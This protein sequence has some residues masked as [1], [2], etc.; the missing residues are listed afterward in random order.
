MIEARRPALL[1]VLGEL[2]NRTSY[3]HLIFLTGWRVQIFIRSIF[4]D[5]EPDETES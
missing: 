5:G 4:A 2:S 1:Q 3:I